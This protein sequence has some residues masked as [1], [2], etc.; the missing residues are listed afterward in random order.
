[1]QKKK[2]KNRNGVQ[3]SGR[4]EKSN[5]VLNMYRINAISWKG[6][7]HLSIV[8]FEIG[9]VVCIV[10]LFGDSFIMKGF[11]GAPE[12]GIAVIV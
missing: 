3:K 5:C 1:M 4:E 12:A 8:Y 11:L 2:E 7:D 9:S 10:I 6:L